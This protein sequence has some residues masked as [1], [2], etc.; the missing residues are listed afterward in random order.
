[1][2]LELERFR[3]AMGMMLGEFAERLHGQVDVLLPA[4]EI[5]EKAM[6]DAENVYP[7][8][9][10]VVIE[11]ECPFLDHIVEVKRNKELKEERSLLLYRERMEHG[12]N[13]RMTEMKA[14][15][16]NQSRTRLI[17]ITSET[18]SELLWIT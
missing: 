14:N 2:E 17:R 9:E 1:M 12:M 16:S 18:A 3:L 15:S 11:R 13:V 5:V 7:S 8:K 4:R 6:K 10:I